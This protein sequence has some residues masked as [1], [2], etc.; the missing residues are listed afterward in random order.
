VV[1]RLLDGCEGKRTSSKCAGI[2]KCP[3]DDTSSDDNDDP[4]ASGILVKDPV[5]GRGISY[6]TPPIE[7]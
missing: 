7:Q 4:I 6:S 3:Q 5:V 1:N 2:T